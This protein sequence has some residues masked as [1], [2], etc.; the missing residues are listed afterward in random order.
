[1]RNKLILAIVVIAV[2]LIADQLF[3]FWIKTSFTIGE[4][5]DVLGDWF[6]LHFTENE[7]MAFGLKLPG[8]W[9]KLFLTFFR[10]LAVSGIV[11]Y[12]VL[13]IKQDAQSSTIFLLALIVA[14][15]LGNSID[16]V[17]YGQWFT[18]SGVL[19]K[20]TW[21]DGGNGYAP[22][23]HG[24]VVDMFYFP[25]FS[26]AYPDWVPIKGGQSFTFFSA[27]FNIADAAISVGLFSIL[28]FKRDLFNQL[29]PNHDSAR[30]TENEKTDEE[31]A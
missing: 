31:I 7:G 20:A 18:E 8:T 9:G 6:K 22:Y 1:M 17:F 29:T 28:L 14:G 12:L 25:L 19:T 13:Q 5:I 10:L 4:E 27:I 16:G 21:S 23:L 3:K 24:K 2:L 30:D 11:Y 26:G 15:A